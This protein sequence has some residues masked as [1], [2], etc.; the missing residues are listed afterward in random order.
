MCPAISI[1]MLDVRQAILR[2]RRLSE[3]AVSAGYAS[4]ELWWLARLTLSCTYPLRYSALRVTL[5][6]GWREGRCD[7]RR[8]DLPC[9]ATHM[10]VLY[11][12]AQRI[13]S[14]HFDKQ[15]LPFPLTC[16]SHVICRLQSA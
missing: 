5:E 1:G 6:G 7:L 9:C 8:F 2:L 12:R 16:I 15:R 14:L 3:D 4:L 11:L 10:T 13:T